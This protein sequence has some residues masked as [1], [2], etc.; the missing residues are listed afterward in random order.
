MV[1]SQI[2][3]GLTQLRELLLVSLA[4][5]N[6][7]LCGLGLFDGLLDGDEPAIALLEGLGLESVLVSVQ[8]EEEGDC[9]ILAGIGSFRL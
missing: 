5:N 6:F 9:A 7:L 4:G 1:A 8:L 3:E 2:E